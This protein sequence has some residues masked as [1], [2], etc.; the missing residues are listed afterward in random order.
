MSGG[1]HI[2]TSCWKF[3]AKTINYRG[4]CCRRLPV[5]LAGPVGLALSDNYS[6]P[7]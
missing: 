2:S 3:D 7:I 6:V 5:R 1:L 4:D